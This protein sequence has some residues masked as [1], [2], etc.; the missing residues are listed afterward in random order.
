MNRAAVGVDGVPTQ[1]VRSWG[2]GA[3]RAAV[4][5]LL[6]ATP[7]CNG[8][9]TECS[10]VSPGFTVT[11]TTIT[12][13]DTTPASQ[14]MAS[15][16]ACA[17]ATIT[18]ELPTAGASACTTYRVVPSAP[19]ACEV[20]LYFSSGTDDEQDVNIVEATGCCSGY[21]ADPPSA[22]DVE[23]PAPAAAPDGGGGGTDA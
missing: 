22:G 9:K 12:T 8:D 23:F 3:T 18:C 17:A 15:G 6:F 5:A 10:C 13:I 1:G 14:L 16:P 19:G 21:Y 7:A 4:A 11:I 20:D 2:S